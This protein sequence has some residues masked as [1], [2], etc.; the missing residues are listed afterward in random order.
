MFDFAFMAAAPVVG[1]AVN[2]ARGGWFKNI[3]LPW[4]PAKLIG[5]AVIAAVMF[6]FSYSL[7]TLGVVSGLYWLGASWGW[8]KWIACLPAHLTQKEYNY[9][10]AYPAYGDSPNYE[11]LLHKVI[12]DKKN[13]KTYVFVGGFIRGALWFVPVYAALWWFDVVSLPIAAALAVAASV[14]FPIAY[15]IGYALNSKR[16]L[17]PSELV[18]GAITWALLGYAFFG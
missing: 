2:R 8:T 1:A 17:A 4:V 13:Y 9:K 10:F 15:K 11:A 6:W 18:Y 14:A 16:W 7:I 12:D 5:P 3:G